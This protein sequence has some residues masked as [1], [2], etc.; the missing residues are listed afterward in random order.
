MSYTRAVSNSDE[1]L[2]IIYP[3]LSYQDSLNTLGL[4][5]LHSR[6]RDPCNKPFESVLNDEE[7]KLHKLLPPKVT[8]NTYNFRNNKP[9]NMPKQGRIEQIV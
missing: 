4:Q 2:R 6:R 7:H 9:F 1:W 3:Q 8:S 5:T